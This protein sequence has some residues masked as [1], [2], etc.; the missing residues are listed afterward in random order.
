MIQYVLSVV[1]LYAVDFH[2][3]VTRCKFVIK[4]SGHTSLECIMLNGE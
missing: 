3:Y 1:D 2:G 4:A